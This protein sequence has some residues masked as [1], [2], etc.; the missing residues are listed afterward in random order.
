MALSNRKKFVGLCNWN[1][2][3]LRQAI[4]LQIVGISIYTINILW[5]SNNTLTSQ[6]NE[7]SDIEQK[8]HKFV[9]NG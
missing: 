7:K 1:F 5:K 6:T 3:F 4:I 9:T 2:I 8:L